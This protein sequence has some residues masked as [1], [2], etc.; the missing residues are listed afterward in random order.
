M[1]LKSME[2]LACVRL[3]QRPGNRKNWYVF[4]TPKDRQIKRILVPLA[5]E[6]NALA[7]RG[8]PD[9][10]VAIVRQALLVMIEN[11]AQDPALCE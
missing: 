5:E 2:K 9:K 8:L 1:A 10:N 4:L 7:L 3:E 11:L 6:S